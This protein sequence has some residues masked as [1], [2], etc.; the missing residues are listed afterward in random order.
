MH[1]VFQGGSN[2]Y[3]IFRRAESR[4]A[5]WTGQRTEQRRN[6]PRK[7]N[8]PEPATRD[9]VATSGRCTVAVRAMTQLD[10]ESWCV[11]AGALKT[12]LGRR[13]Q[14]VAELLSDRSP[15]TGRSLT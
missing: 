1:A 6:W 14:P 9:E 10:W 13:P 7:T 4:I 5:G 2:P 15:Q 3:W 8:V 12:F 11:G